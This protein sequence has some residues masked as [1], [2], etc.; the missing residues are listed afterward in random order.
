MVLA[1]TISMQALRFLLSPNGRLRPQPFIFGAVAVY[2]AGVASHLLTKPD[3]IVRTGLWPFMAVQ[4]ILI[5]IWFVLHAR[6]LH[7]ANRA[8]GIAAGAGVLYALSIVLLLIL[9]IGFSNPA[10]SPMS[11]PNA[12]VALNLIVILYAIATLPGSGLDD[13]LA[14]AIIASLTVLAFL[15]IIIML[16]LTLWAATRP[17]VIN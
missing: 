2:L 6:R 8:I 15:P 3:V 10:S 14:W 12:G 9:S 4:L 13:Q 16:V 17:S 7:D 5:W 1:G 11:N